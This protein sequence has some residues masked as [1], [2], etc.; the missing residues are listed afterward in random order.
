MSWQEFV[1]VGAGFAVSAAIFA[2]LERVFPARSGQPVV[3]P[4]LGVDILYFLSGAL[5]W[6][7]VVVVT[8]DG[9]SAWIANGAFASARQAMDS[10]PLWTRAVVV[11]MLGE[12]GVYWFHR[13]C[14][15]VPLLWRFHAVHHSVEHLD[16][17]AANREHPL[18]GFFTRLILNSPAVLLGFDLSQLSALIVFRG[19]WA[20]FIHSNVRV[21]LGPLRWFF[22]AP[23]LH[24]WH[25]H[26]NPRRVANFANLGPWVDW[27]FGTYER[28]SEAVEDWP[29]GVPDSFPRGFLAQHVEPFLRRN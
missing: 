11:L 18:D 5:V 19:L 20:V 24:H 4:E 9:L 10:L 28:P 23:D 26:K 2:P 17:V 13:A 22:G 14:H 8:L 25:H 12:L 16:W 1:G 7:A 21:P 6:N 3:R 15:H 29:I 27:L